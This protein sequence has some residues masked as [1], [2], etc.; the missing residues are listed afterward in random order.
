[1]VRT[2]G[3]RSF[4]SYPRRKVYI[5]SIE[6]LQEVTTVMSVMPGPDKNES[7]QTL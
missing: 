3:K 5:T 6:K 1:M 4:G 2:E 7:Q